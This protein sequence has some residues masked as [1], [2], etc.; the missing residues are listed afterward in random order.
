MS[1]AT[2]TLPDT[3][4]PAAEPARPAEAA[5]TPDPAAELPLTVIERRP[6]WH[7]V[8]LRELW[9]YRELL[10]FLT[11]R[12]V[13][14]RYKQT[15]LGAAWAVLQP[16]ATMIVFTVFLGRMGG[17]SGGIKNYPLF[18]F[19]AMLAWTFFQNALTSAGGSVVGN[20]NL[21]TKVY[22]PRLIVPMGAIGAGLVDFAV[23][24][25]MLALMM[26]YYGVFGE[27]APAVP[28]WSLLLA[29]LVV[30]LL[31]LAAL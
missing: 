7:L 3:V 30:L 16:V 24:L 25:V 26:V 8:N 17:V 13:K 29:P 19:A 12:D 31:V 15:A 5:P 23:T 9:H 2:E 27:T 18:V 10:Y 14:V 22:F 1:T 11:W 21:I 4:P 28:G 20:Q 6:G